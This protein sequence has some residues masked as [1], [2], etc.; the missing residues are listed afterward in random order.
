MAN[1]SS[2]ICRVQ[3]MAQMNQSTE[4]KHAHRRKEQTC[5][6]QGR[7]GKKWDGLGVCRY[8]LLGLGWKDNEILLYGTRNYIQS[9]G[10]DHDRR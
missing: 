5:G 1:D 4:Q 10:K 7:R 2:F 3:N 6:F 9:L 8:K